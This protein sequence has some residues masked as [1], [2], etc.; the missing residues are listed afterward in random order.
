[1]ITFEFAQSLK[2]RFVV[3]RVERAIAHGC[4]RSAQRWG[5]YLHGR[6]KLLDFE[7]WMADHPGH[8]SANCITALF[9]Y[10]SHDTQNQVFEMVAACRRAQYFTVWAHSIVREE[11]LASLLRWR[12]MDIVQQVVDKYD[13]T[14]LTWVGLRFSQPEIYQKFYPLCEHDQ[15]RHMLEERVFEN[16]EKIY[17]DM[18]YHAQQRSENLEILAQ[19]QGLKIRALLGGH[20]EC[21]RRK[22]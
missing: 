12:H 5:K 10:A 18:T 7:Q 15:V 16:R 6:L 11:F 20:G 1:M 9:Y 17:W 13:P 4:V 2:H 8:S 3:N 21:T 22:I 14:F 19:L